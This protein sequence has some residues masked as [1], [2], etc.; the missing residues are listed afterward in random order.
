MRLKLLAVGT[1]MPD[2]V[3]SG[4]QEYGKRMPPELRIQVIEISLGTRG[5]N[6]PKAKAIEAESQGLLKAIGEQ[7]FVVALDVLGKPM[8]TE[9]LAQNLGNWQMNGR[10]V[11]LLVGGPDGLSANCLARANMR[12]SLS[13]LTL[14]HPLVRIVVMEQLYRAWTINANHPYHRS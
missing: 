4:C 12:W 1:R 11:C 13:D 3:E 5:K 2:W 14:P 8:S 6:Q 10:D 9:K 7:D